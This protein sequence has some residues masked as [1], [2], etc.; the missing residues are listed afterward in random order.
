MSI[1]RNEIPKPL[2]LNFMLECISN[3]VLFNTINNRILSASSRVTNK[4]NENEYPSIPKPQLFNTQTNDGTNCV[5]YAN[6]SLAILTVNAFGFYFENATSNTN[7]GSSLSMTSTNMISNLTGFGNSS[8]TPPL[9]YQNLKNSYSTIVYDYVPKRSFSNNTNKSKRSNSLMSSGLGIY[10]DKEKEKEK[11]ESLLLNLS[12]NGD[13]NKSLLNKNNSNKE[14][15]SNNNSGKNFKKEKNE[16]HLLAIIAPSGNCVCYRK[17]GKPRYFCT[18]TGGCLVN[19]KGIA[20]Y[21]WRWD[22]Q[23]TIDERVRDELCSDV[24]SFLINIDL[25]F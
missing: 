25:N 13:K 7:P 20:F 24:I 15:S 21:Q 19:S 4:A 23:T 8:A 16:S 11:Q 5:Y 17:N 6:G 2:D 14:N 1:L 22:D 9:S 10:N 3:P 18:E 12:F